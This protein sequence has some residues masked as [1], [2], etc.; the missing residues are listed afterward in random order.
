MATTKPPIQRSAT[1]DAVC[2]LITEQLAID[3]DEMTPDARI[4]D[5][6]GADSLDFIELVMACEETFGIE[7]DEET[8]ERLQTVGAL[9]AHVEKLQA[10]R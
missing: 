3:V 5:D 2:Q 9:V 1:Y 8:A 7:I 6:L 10:R 4:I